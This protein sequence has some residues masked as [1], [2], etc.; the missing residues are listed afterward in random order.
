MFLMIKDNLQSLKNC[1]QISNEERRQS[2]CH[3]TLH[4]FIND[5]KF[6]PI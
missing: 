2:E 1:V 3:E 6:F 5:A 4:D